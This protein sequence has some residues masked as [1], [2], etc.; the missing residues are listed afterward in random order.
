MSIKSNF[1]NTLLMMCLYFAFLCTGCSL[2]QL[3]PTMNCQ[4]VK[5]ER[6]Q[7]TASVNAE[8]CKV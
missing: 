8:G 7:D 4:Y 3:S 2:I 6:I 5:Y 1:V